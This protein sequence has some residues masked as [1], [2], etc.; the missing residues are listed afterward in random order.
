MGSAL[1]NLLKHDS[2]VGGAVGI[3]AKGVVGVG[4]S[5]GLAR[6][7][8]G[9]KDA[10]S[11]KVYLGA[12]AG[13][14]IPALAHLVW[15]DVEGVGGAILGGLDAAGQGAADFLAV[16]H[17][18]GHARQAKGVRPIL[19]PAGADLKV[20]PAG[21]ITDAELV[22]LRDEVTLGTLSLAQPGASLD[23]DQ[24]REIQAYR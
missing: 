5:Y 11:G 6:H 1:R 2:H 8:H 17:G 20:L 7:F 21:A 18:L 3:L 13:K 23:L 16:V 4:T 14:V 9:K 24:L 19:V 22:G 15:G 10:R 12:I